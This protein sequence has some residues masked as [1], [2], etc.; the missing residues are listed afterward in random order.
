MSHRDSDKPGAGRRAREGVRF[1]LYPALANAMA[2]VACLGLVARFWGIRD[3][4][5]QDT[6][7]AAMVVFALGTLAGG[8]A[9]V[10]SRFARFQDGG[11]AI[12]WVFL[13]SVPLSGATFF[14]G[15][16]YVLFTLYGSL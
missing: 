4:V 2:M 10:A 1:A 12:L 8:A 15:A 9:L 11:G 7:F 5:M 6:V 16:F 14:I 3:V 13:V